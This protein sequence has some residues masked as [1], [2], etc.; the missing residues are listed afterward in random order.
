MYFSF[1]RHF[2]NICKV[3]LSCT[4]LQN[5]SD[6]VISNMDYPYECTE[7]GSSRILTLVCIYDIVDCLKNR[8]IPSHKV[9]P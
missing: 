4:I 9:F 3:A 2:C 8:E 7:Q 6:A 5:I 1:S